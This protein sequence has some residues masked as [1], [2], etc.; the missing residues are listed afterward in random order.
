[1][2]FNIPIF[3]FEVVIKPNKYNVGPDNL[4]Q[5]ELGDAGGILDDELLD[6]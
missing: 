2:D 6:S 3:D 1:M 4:S 5:I